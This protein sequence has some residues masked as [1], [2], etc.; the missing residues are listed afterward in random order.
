[1]SFALLVV[2]LMVAPPRVVLF[3]VYYLTQRR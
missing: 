1:M 2:L 3:G